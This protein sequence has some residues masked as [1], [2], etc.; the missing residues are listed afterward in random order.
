MQSVDYRQCKNLEEVA[1]TTVSGL[2]TV[3]WDQFPEYIRRLP[4]FLKKCKS[5]REL[6]TNQGG[7]ASVALL[8]NLDYYELVDKS[9]RNFNPIKKHFDDYSKKNNIEICYHEMSSLEVETDVET[10][11][12]LIDSVHKYKHVSAEIKLY[13]PLT[14][15]YMMFHDTFGF[16][17]V[18]QAVRDFLEE[19]K[20][21]KLIE[22]QNE[23]PG[24]MV[25]ERE[26]NER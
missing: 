11:F 22:E 18:G 23:T 8:E 26:L 19:N 10:D 9:F 13:E 15:K 3:Y 12:I 16:P 25:L 2:A 1:S 5:Y 14:K 4:N 7:S 17:R 6:G 21:W 20:N 24:Y